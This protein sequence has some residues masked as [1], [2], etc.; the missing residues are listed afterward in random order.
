MTSTTTMGSSFKAKQRSTTCTT[1]RPIKS[2]WQNSHSRRTKKIRRQRNASDLVTRTG[3][4]FSN[5]LGELLADRVDALLQNVDGHIGFFL[6]HDQR[7]TQT[8]RARS[9]TEEENALFEG[10]LHDAVAFSGAVF[11]GDFV[12][13][14]IDADHQPAPAN[15]ANQLQLR[16]PLRHALHHVSAHFRGILE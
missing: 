14:D 4:F 13:H 6:R 11:L 16:R 5:L 2:W 9:A 10:H 15:V 1:S 7:R 3:A 12:L 8:N